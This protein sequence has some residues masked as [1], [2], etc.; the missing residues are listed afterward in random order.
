M[1][2]I[3]INKVDK[4]NDRV[5][6]REGEDPKIRDEEV[7]VPITTQGYGLSHSTPKYL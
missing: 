7:E 1:N 3:R 4:I 5:A 2:S 6:G